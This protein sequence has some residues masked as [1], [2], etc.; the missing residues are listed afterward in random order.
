M[1]VLLNEA[2]EAGFTAGS[3]KGANFDTDWAAFAAEFHADLPVELKDEFKK[4]FSSALSYRM[5]SY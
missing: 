1:A 5:D 2:R 4:G 3:K